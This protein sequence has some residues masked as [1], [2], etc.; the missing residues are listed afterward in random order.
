MTIDDIYDILNHVYT[1]KIERLTYESV[2]FN[3]DKYL[4]RYIIIPFLIFFMTF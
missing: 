4:S 1:H 3:I 2:L